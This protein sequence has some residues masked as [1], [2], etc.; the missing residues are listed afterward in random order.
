MFQ[1]WTVFMF[2]ESWL[3]DQLIQKA[4]SDDHAEEMLNRL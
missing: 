3:C 4:Y 1:K 2:T